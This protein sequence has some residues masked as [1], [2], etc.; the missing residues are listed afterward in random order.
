MGVAKRIA[1]SQV[2]RGSRRLAF[3]FDWK[4]WPSRIAP[5]LASLS[6]RHCASRERRIG[7]PAREEWAT[8]FIGR[9]AAAP[10]VALVRISFMAIRTSFPML[11]SP[12]LESRI[13]LTLRR[14]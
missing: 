10:L 13:G 3:G 6:L 5:V 7:P 4:K 14:R 1:P 12:F 9:R 11:M 8:H 2:V